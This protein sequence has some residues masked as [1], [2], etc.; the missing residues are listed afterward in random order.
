MSVRKTALILALA[1]VG[2]AGEVITRSRDGRRSYAAVHSP[3]IPRF[4]P[5][6]TREEA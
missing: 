5:S 6:V 3:V 2:A 1:A 4:S